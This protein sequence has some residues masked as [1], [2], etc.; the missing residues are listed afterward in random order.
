[1]VKKRSEKKLLP[2]FIVIQLYFF[3]LA[4]VPLGSIEDGLKLIN[5]I[6][7]FAAV[8]FVKKRKTSF[9]LFFKLIGFSLILNFLSCSYF[10]DQGFLVSLK[11]SLFICQ[12]YFFLCLSSL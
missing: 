5:W 10:R 2:V 3:N 1:M 12:I 11:T 8:F 9:D 7:L 6:L 4:F